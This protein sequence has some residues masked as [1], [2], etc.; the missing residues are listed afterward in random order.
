LKKSEE[1]EIASSAPFW[2]ES[3][4]KMPILAVPLSSGAT[5]RAKFKALGTP[6]SS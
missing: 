2:I 6:E 3:P 4:G 5:V 1:K